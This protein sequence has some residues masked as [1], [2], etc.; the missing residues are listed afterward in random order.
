MDEL[1]PDKSDFL[2][3][4]FFRELWTSEDR[5]S[6]VRA[7]VYLCSEP[8]TLDGKADNCRQILVLRANKTRTTYLDCNDTIFLMKQN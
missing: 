4:G 6:V 3:L 8:V 2:S 5:C 7:F 1:T